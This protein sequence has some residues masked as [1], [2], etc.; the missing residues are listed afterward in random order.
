MESNKNDTK[1]LTKQTDSKTLKPNWWLP[2]GKHHGGRDKLGVGGDTC[3][4]PC[5]KK[6]TNKDPL[7]ST[8][9]FLDIL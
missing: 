2:T 4:P 5:I 3:T 1:E 9:N 6:G 7:R 8:G